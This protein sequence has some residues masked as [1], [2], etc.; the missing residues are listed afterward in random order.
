MKNLEVLA[1]D[2]NQIQKVFVPLFNF[3]FIDTSFLQNLS[4]S[5]KL[6]ATFPY[7]SEKACST[8]YAPEPR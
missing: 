8:W 5:L 7:N 2:D 6:S 3:Y 4:S 1:L